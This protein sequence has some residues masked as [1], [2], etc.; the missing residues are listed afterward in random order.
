[1]FKTGQVR[2]VVVTVTLVLTL[3]MPLQYALLV[4]VG[5]SMILFIIRQANRVVTWSFVI[6]GGGRIRDEDPS[7]AFS[8]QDPGI[9]ALWFSFQGD[10]F[11]SRRQERSNEW[12]EL[13]PQLQRKRDRPA[14]QPS[15]RRCIPQ[16]PP[17]KRQ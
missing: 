7:A 15:R 14:I 8:W 13:V 16:R 6:H 1:V 5:I 2:V 12:P 10:V 11:S 4:G 3:L 17:V 9:L